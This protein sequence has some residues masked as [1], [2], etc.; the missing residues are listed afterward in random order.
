MATI[1]SDAARTSHRMP[2]SAGRVSSRDTAY[3]VSLIMSIKV[4]AGIAR[5]AFSSGFFSAGKSFTFIVFS[6]RRDLPLVSVSWSPFCEIVT[7]PGRR[8]RTNGTNFTAGIA[9]RPGSLTVAFVV[10]VVIEMSRFVAES[11]RLSFVA[12]TSTQLRMGRVVLLGTTAAMTSRAFC[13]SSCWISNFT[14]RPP[15]GVW[16]SS[17]RGGP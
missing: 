16:R 10:E 13:R 7:T 11:V 3:A 12:S 6:V 5:A 1:V 17:F 14:I 8:L 15:R 4:S 9:T 2:I